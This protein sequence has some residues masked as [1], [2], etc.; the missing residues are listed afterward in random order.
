MQKASVSEE[1][2]VEDSRYITDS[3]VLLPPRVPG[4]KKLPRQSRQ[5]KHA[6]KIKKGDLSEPLEQIEPFTQSKY[7]DFLQPHPSNEIPNETFNQPNS[8]KTFNQPNSYKTVNHSKHSFEPSY[9]NDQRNTSLENMES[10]PTLKPQ[11]IQKQ[12]DQPVRKSPFE[13]LTKSKLDQPEEPIYVVN[14]IEMIN[15]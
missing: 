12:I 10:S 2:E 11:D 13:M 9:Q 8:Y 15:N 14:L 3:S 7:D 1:E 5:G 6:K 4:T